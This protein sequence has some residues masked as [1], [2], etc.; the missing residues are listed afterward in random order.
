M[1]KSAP[2]TNALGQSL[3]PD[4]FNEVRRPSV[5]TAA[6]PVVETPPQIEK[7]NPLAGMVASKVG[8]K[9]YTYYLDDDVALA[10][11]KL[12]K[13]NKISKSKVVNLLLKD[14]LLNK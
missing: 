1:A 12:A 13:Q 9:A 11:E 2:K 14:I 5:T 6:E 8:A 7:T 10:I 4:T 3:M